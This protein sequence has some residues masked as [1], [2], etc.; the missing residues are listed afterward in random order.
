M[1]VTAFIRKTVS[2][3]NVTDLARVYFRASR[4]GWR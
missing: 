4:Q 1:K 2:K 3:N